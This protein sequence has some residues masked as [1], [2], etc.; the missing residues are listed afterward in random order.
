[1][2]IIFVTDSGFVYNKQSYL[3]FDVLPN[4]YMLNRGIYVPI[5]W[6]FGLPNR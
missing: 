4:L 2:I 6:E 1:M 3:N 5:S